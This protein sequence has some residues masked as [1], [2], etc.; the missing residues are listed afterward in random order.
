[1]QN[2]FL[3]KFQQFVGFRLLTSEQKK[4]LRNLIVVEGSEYPEQ[5]EKSVADLPGHSKEAYEKLHDCLCIELGKLADVDGAL[6]DPEVHSD[7]GFNE[8]AFAVDRFVGP[9]NPVGV[10]VEMKIPGTVAAVLNALDNTEV[11]YCIMLDLDEAE[12]MILKNGSIAISVHEGNPRKII[13][14][15]L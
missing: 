15:I 4:Q 5:F 3:L 10:V 7:S 13:K 12:V 8:V 2:L 9:S 14:T 11:D 1:M 6:N